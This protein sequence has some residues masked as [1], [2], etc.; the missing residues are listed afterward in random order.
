MKNNFNSYLNQ[1]SEN[2]EDYKNKFLNKLTTKSDVNTPVQLKIIEAANRE[3]LLVERIIGFT[4]F[5]WEFLIAKYN[6]EVSQPVPFSIFDEI[7]C[8][9][10]LVE[11]LSKRKIGEILGLNVADD[12]AERAIVE[13]SL[14]S[15]KD[16]DIIEGTTDGYQLTDIGK[17]YAKNGIK[18]SYF[19]RNFTIYF[20]TTGR[21]QEHAKSEL[22]KLK[23]EKSQLPVKAVPI[24]LE[25]I[26]EFAVF[27]GP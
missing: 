18:Y 3:K 7:I 1:N 19:N 22:R 14:K 13:K 5:D 4:D 20:D 24:S 17:E 23:S 27:S 21:N 6:G 15:L 2:Y 26:R 9:L 11:N 10:L 8:D 12:P 25:Q 16:E